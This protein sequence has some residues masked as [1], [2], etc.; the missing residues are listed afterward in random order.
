MERA[1]AEGQP[2]VVL[3]LAAQPLVRRSYSDPVGTFSANVQGT[4]PACVNARRQ[5]GVPGG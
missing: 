4:D 1:F 2:E 5:Y 3:H